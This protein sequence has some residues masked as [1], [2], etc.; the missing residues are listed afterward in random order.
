[1]KIFGSLEAQVMPIMWR[2]G[3]ATVKQIHRELLDWRAIVYTTV[4]TAMERLEQKGVLKREKRGLAY[5]YTLALSREEYAAQA[6][7][8]II[9]EVL[10]GDA[11]GLACAPLKI[12]TLCSGVIARQRHALIEPV[13]HELPV[14]IVQRAGI[15]RAIIPD[16]PTGISKTLRLAWR[17]RSAD[18]LLLLIAGNAAHIAIGNRFGF[19]RT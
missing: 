2:D 14:L 16:R 7:R 13:A 11:R 8:Q 3:Q 4:M 17:E 1:M 18:S 6:V 19:I 9:D 10:D 15:G 5:M 12:S